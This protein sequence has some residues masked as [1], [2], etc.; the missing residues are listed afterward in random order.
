MHLWFSIPD[1]HPCQFSTS[2][3]ARNPTASNDRILVI[4]ALNEPGTAYC[5]ARRVDVEPGESMH[6]P[7]IL[8]AGWRRGCCFGWPLKLRRNGE[9]V[10]YIVVG[11]GLQKSDRPLWTRSFE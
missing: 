11:L 3:S 10:C 7:D 8:A 9:A 1:I 6:I 5:R 4:F 2:H